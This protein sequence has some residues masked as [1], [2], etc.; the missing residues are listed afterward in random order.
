MKPKSSGKADPVRLQQVGEFPGT[1]ARVN[2]KVV[3]AVGIRLRLLHHPTKR[4]LLL[5]VRHL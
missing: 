3:D 5:L 1:G 4:Q 2:V